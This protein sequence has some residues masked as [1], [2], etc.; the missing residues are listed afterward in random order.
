MRRDFSLSPAGRSGRPRKPIELMMTPMI[1]VIFLL[2]VFFVTTSSF[3]VMEQLLPSTL[4]ES[5]SPIGNAAE[6]PPVP[7]QDALDQIVIRLKIVNQRAVANLNGSDLES[8]EQLPGRLRAISAVRADVPVIIDPE[9]QVPAKDVVH[10][11]DWARQSGL[12]RVHL[13]IAGGSDG[14]ME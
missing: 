7:T 3:Q 10:A 1:D 11:Y 9:G 13:A 2:L 12:S 4:S 5:Q 8:F 6:P 14:V